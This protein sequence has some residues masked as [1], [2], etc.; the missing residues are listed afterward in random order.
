MGTL[1]PEGVPGRTSAEGQ[2]FESRNSSKSP[3]SCSSG[4]STTPS[5]S[6]ACSSTRSA[7]SGRYGGAGGCPG[8][9]GAP[10]RSLLLTPNLCGSHR[11]SCAASPSSSS[12]WG[13]SSPPSAWSTRS[14]RTRTKTRSG[15]EARGAAWGART[16]FPPPAPSPIPSM[17]SRLWCFT[18]FLGSL[19][20]GQ[21]S[22]MDC[23]A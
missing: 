3:L 16:V 4:S 15:I 14:F 18:P 12:S 22:Q 19:G 20:V 13:T 17:P 10:G 6:S 2:A 9:G 8:V 11:S 7:R 21:S 1:C 23:G 5:P